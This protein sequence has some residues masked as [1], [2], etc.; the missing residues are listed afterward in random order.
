MKSW[1]Y[2]I[3]FSGGRQLQLGG[4]SR[5]SPLVFGNEHEICVEW[6]R[7]YNSGHIGSEKP[8]ET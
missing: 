3:F 7:S 8:A 4:C 5:Q 1:K 6:C 2:F